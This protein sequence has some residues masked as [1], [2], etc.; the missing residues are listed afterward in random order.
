[1]NYITGQTIT[2]IFL[3]TDSNNNPVVPANFSAVTFQD[4]IEILSDSI[5]FNLYLVDSYLGIYNFSF[6]PQNEGIY[7]VYINN[8][9]TKVIYVSETYLVSNTALPSIYVGI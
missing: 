4:G 5:S 1:M 6:I 9:T 8:L 2:E 7:Q 3:S